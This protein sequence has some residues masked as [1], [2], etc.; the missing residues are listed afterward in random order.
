MLSQVSQL[1]RLDL[2]HTGSSGALA[3]ALAGPG[4]RA[5]RCSAAARSSVARRTRRP[6]GVYA[7]G[8]VLAAPALAGSARPSGR[9]R[10]PL[11][12]PRLLPVVATGGTLALAWTALKVGALRV[13]RRLRDRPADAVGRRRHLPLDEPCAQFAE[14]RRPRP[15]R[16]P[17]PSL[18]TVA[19]VGFSRAAAS[20]GGLLA[21]ADRVQ[22]PR[23]LFVLARRA[24]ASSACWRPTDG[25]SPSSPAPRRPPPARSSAAAIPLAA[26]LERGLAATACSPAAAA[27]CCSACAAAS[28]RRCSPAGARRRA[29]AALLGA[30]AAAL[31]TLLHRRVTPSLPAWSQESGRLRGNLVAMDGGAA[32]SSVTGHACEARADHALPLLRLRGA[33]ATRAFSA[34]PACPSARPRPRR[35]T[36]SPSGAAWTSSTMHRPRHDRRHAAASPTAT[37]SMFVSEGSRGLGSRS[38]G[39]RG[40]CACLASESTGEDHEWL[41]APRL[42]HRLCRGISLHQHGIVWAPGLPFCAVAAPFTAPPGPPPCGAVRRVGGPEQRRAPPELDPARRPAYIP[43]PARAWASSAAA[44]T[45]PVATSGAPT[46]RRPPRHDVRRSSSRTCAPGARRARGEQG[47]AAKWA[48]AAIALAARA[49]GARRRAPARARTRARARRWRSRL[50]REGDARERRDRR[51]S[52][53]PEDARCLLRAWL[54]AVELDHLDERGL[55]AYMQQRGLQPRRP[56]PPRAAARTSGKLRDA[57]VER[58]SAPST[59]TREL[60]AA[61][62]RASSTRA[63]PRSPTRPRRAFLASEKAKLARCPA[64]ARRARARRRRAPRVAIIADGIGSHARRDAHDRGDPPARRAG[65]R[66]RGD[67]HRPGRRPAPLGGGR[68]RGALLPGAAASA[69]RA[70]PAAVRDARRGPLRRDPRL[71]ARARRASP[72]RCSRAR[73]RPAA[74]SAATTPSSPP[75]PGLRSRRRASSREAMAVA[76]RAPSTAPA[77]SSSPRAPPPTRRSPAIG[78]HARARRRAGIAASTPRA[79]T[80]ALRDGGPRPRDELDQRALRRAHHAREGRRAA[81]RRVPARPTRAIRGCTSCSPAAAPRRSACASA[82]ASAP[83]FLGW[84]DGRGARA[85]LRRAPT[86]SCSRAPPTPSAR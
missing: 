85:R 11:C 41:Q 19:A 22:R 7:L 71:L 13:R 39:A 21:A 73:M 67:R 29:S 30:P 74:R 60:R 49:L 4:P 43:P 27:V 33:P 34:R 75:T 23:S 17:V 63:S 53:T 37:P 78:M 16:R 64:R 20:A 65:L 56:L 48:H 82:S 72:A 24:A 28:S 66:D 59:A 51:A 62:A 86:S 84:L 46:P 15:G 47:S 83:R 2:R 42:R 68:G 3:A 10:R 12:R 1:A 79:S 80:R 9:P 55:I 77:T 5:R 76:R 35:S 32:A 50:L 45:T 61:A 8:P 6:G 38:A 36:S 25:R 44:T 81:R 14:R 54:A 31:R 58:R 70:S 69:C 57:V 26:G 40:R 18:Q 52:L